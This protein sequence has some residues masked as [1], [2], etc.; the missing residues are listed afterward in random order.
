MYAKSYHSL[1]NIMALLSTFINVN[2]QLDYPIP[3]R[4]IYIYIEIYLSPPTALGNR[5]YGATDSS[6]DLQFSYLA[7]C[8][9]VSSVSLVVVRH[10]VEPYCSLGAC[11][12]IDVLPGE[13]TLSSLRLSVQHNP[14]MRSVFQSQTRRYL[15][16]SI[17]GQLFPSFWK[18]FASILVCCFTLF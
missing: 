12:K 2:H 8:R 15:N 17:W 10:S 9:I 3:R 7:N 1:S 14:G 5:L 4:C 13:R 11:Q 18:H 16:G 6:C